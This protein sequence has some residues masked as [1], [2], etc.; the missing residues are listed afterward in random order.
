MKKRIVKILEAH[1]RYGLMTTE[2]MCS[3]FFESR[4]PKAAE[5]V[6]TRLID[7]GLLFGFQL[8]DSKKYYV[9]TTKGYQVL[10][11]YNRWAGTSLGPQ[12]L[13]TNLSILNYCTLGEPRSE[14]MTR[15]EFLRLFPDL[16]AC[17]VLGSSH[18]TKF[19]LD[20]AEPAQ[21]RLGLFV[22]AF[23]R[24]PWRVV[25]KCRREIHRRAEA[26]D[27]YKEMIATELLSLT[28]LT[29]HQSKASRLE[30]WLESEPFHS[31]VVVVPGIRDFLGR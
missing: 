9:L 29:F 25:K 17:G 8:S 31:R 16:A 7:A 4:T 12:A 19:H 11:L 5:R 1:A 20:R 15:P 6:R 10:D 2:A 24:N 27:A 21:P 13:L 18:R 14:R 3:L 30:R 22:P 28:V 23:N 26:G